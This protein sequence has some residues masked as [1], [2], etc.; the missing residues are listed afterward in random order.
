MSEEYQI[1]SRAI[2]R[3][4]VNEAYQKIEKPGPGHHNAVT[5]T[6]IWHFRDLLHKAIL[7]KYG[8]KAARAALRAVREA[9]KCY[10]AKLHLN[11]GANALRPDRK[12]NKGYA[13]SFESV[14]NFEGR[15]AVAEKWKDL[16]GTSN[17]ET[18]WKNGLPRM[19][20]I[21]DMG[22]ALSSGSKR[23]FDFLE[24]EVINSVSS[25]S[26]RLHLW[27]WLSKRPQHMRKFAERL[28]G[29]PANICAMTTV[30]ERESLW[31][32]NELREV[33]ASC[34]GLSIEPLWERIPPE[35]LN[36]EGINWVIVG[37]ESGSG[38][39]TKPFHLEWAE[40]ILEH[41]RQNDVAFFLKQL[42]RNP[43]VSGNPFRTSHPHGG[44]WNEWPSHLR[45]REFPA[46]FH[47]YRAGEMPSSNILRP[48]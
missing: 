31:R 5:T 10:A 1:D 22:D 29:L 9:L 13:P 36:L 20:F 15:M 7:E 2:L 41:C 44:D 12:I 43:V 33:N 27:P 45:V 8:R 14:T 47:R 46:Y 37:G 39:L 40:E 42:G 25:D 6:N 18:P 48:A 28:G 3:N 34:R 35:D 21:S 38:D 32:V 11:R 30:T 19:I 4:L 16:L 23:Q 24:H 17:P 26:G